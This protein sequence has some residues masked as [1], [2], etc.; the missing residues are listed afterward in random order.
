M[1]NIL[2]VYKSEPLYFW[3]PILKAFSYELLHLMC[4]L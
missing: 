4:N 1:E 2:W 3:I